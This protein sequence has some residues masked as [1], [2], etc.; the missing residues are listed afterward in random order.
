MPRKLITILGKA[1]QGG[2][3]RTANYQLGEQLKTTS[4]FGLALDEHI[5]SDELIILGT[6]GSMWDNLFIK[7]ELDEQH[8]EVMLALIDAAKEDRVTRE[9]LAP[10]AQAA[11]EKLGKPVICDLI[12]YGRDENEQ[13]A[14]ISQLLGYFDK[15]DSAILDIT[16]GLRHLPMLIEQ[17]ANLL[18]VMR[19]TQIEGVYYGALDLSQN[20]KTPVMRLDGLQQIH[21]WQNALAIYDQTGN[22]A[23]FANLLAKLDINPQAI[24][25]LEQAAFAE[26]THNLRQSRDKIENLLALL[27]KESPNSLLNFLLPSLKERLQ[28]NKNSAPWQQRFDMAERALANKDYL[29]AALYGYEGIFE[30]ILAHQKNSSENYEERKNSVHQ[31]IKQRKNQTQQA[32]RNH[33]YAKDKFVDKYYKLKKIRNMIAHGEEDS[34]IRGMLNN[35]TQLSDNLKDYLLI[36]KTQP[37]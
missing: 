29:R 37:L 17:V 33:R 21:H 2:D 26:Q 5:N 3:Y 20:D 25:I 1:Q 18:P 24:R 15:G 14:I 11:T 12:P 16:H 31:Y 6:T 10:L 19:Q 36:L 27:D 4:Y 8:S 7:L 22:I 28:K 30:R 34:E 13:I 35:E 9:Q 23:I 32:N